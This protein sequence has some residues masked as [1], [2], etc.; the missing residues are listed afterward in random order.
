MK[1]FSM[2]G[3]SL[4]RSKRV[5]VR[6]RV[7]ASLKEAIDL[8]DRFNKDKRGYPLEWDDFIP[9]RNSNQAV[10]QLRNHLADLEL[11]LMS[12]DKKLNDQGVHFG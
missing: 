12:K 6:Q 10:E 1:L 3:D 4:K 8:V 7:I 9:W 2:L 11:S 5:H